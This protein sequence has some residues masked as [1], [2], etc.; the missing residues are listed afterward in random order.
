MCSTP[1]EE[2]DEHFEHLT[3]WIANVHI[4]MEKAKALVLWRLVQ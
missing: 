3:R 2:K 4:D 1:I